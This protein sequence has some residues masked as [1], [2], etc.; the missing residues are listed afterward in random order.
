MTASLA[1]RFLGMD[2]PSPLVASSSPLT[3]RID[4]LRAL[5]DA[6]VGA[7]VLP[8]LFEEQIVHESRELHAMVQETAW[9]NPEAAGGYFPELDDYNTGPDHYLGHL[10][11]AVREVDVPVIA[12]LNGVSMGGW[13][14]HA[15]DLESAGAA[16]IELNVYRLAADV[17]DEPWEVEDDL[18]GIVGRVVDTVAVPVAVKLSPYWSATA[19]L[20]ARL[21]DVGAAG[22]S[23]FNRFY[24]PDIDIDTR[25]IVPQLTLSA[26]HELL[27]P[28]RWVAVLYGRIDTSLAITTGVHD[29][30]GVAKCLLAG[31]DVAMT[32]SAVLRHGPGLVST[33]LD[34]LQRWMEEH[35]YESVGQLRGSASQ[36]AVANPDAFVR[37]NYLQT[38]TSWSTSLPT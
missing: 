8:S 30:V 5:V 23:L 16:A 22:L 7:V 9:N 18:I 35:D 37:A 19:N 28:L 24:Q 12:S 1:T 33:I 38:L 25:D 32:A 3:G 26:P 2:L 20:A 31:A 4:T 14:R 27:L 34:D 36:Q 13:L 6:G 10:E 29:A 17:H 21:V 11:A 15:A